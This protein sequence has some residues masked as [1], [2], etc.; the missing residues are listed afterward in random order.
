MSTPTR[1]VHRH[2]LITWIATAELPLRA[3]AMALCVWPLVTVASAAAAP[4]ATTPRQ[5]GPTAP[6]QIST[7]REVPP[8]PVSDILSE[9]PLDP[10]RAQPPVSEAQ[11]H[12]MTGAS[13]RPEQAV[14]IAPKAAARTVVARG[15]E[16]HPGSGT[17]AV[18]DRVPAARLPTPPSR[19]P[20][21]ASRLGQSGAGEARKV[22][23]S[24]SRS[25]EGRQVN[26]G[27]RRA[28]GSRANA[29][30]PSLPKSPPA[31]AGRPGRRVS[32]A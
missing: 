24:T 3:I 26:R 11:Q 14:G 27:A 4:L 22:G 17:K 8:D 28:P 21:A 6:L 10:T 25:S 30:V 9:L 32:G 15:A 29:R 31:R 18:R 5:K 1:T 12:G 2:G 20:R 19:V 7:A 23:Q 16:P 13:R